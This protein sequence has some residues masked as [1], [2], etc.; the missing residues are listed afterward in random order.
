MPPAFELWSVVA[1][2]SVL[3]GLKSRSG[4]LALPGVLHLLWYDA[5]SSDYV[6]R[7]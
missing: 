4:L 6:A 5:A 7:P 1:I 2:K 3:A